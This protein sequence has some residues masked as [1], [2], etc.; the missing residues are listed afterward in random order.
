MPW[1]RMSSVLMVTAGNALAG[2][3]V[4]LECVLK[5]QGKHE[6]MLPMLWAVLPEW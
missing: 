2:R 1:C 4:Q 3:Q 5:L 6:V